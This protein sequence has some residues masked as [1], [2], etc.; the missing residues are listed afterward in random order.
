MTRRSILFSVV[1]IA[2]FA[3]VTPAHSADPQGAASVQVIKHFLKDIREAAG[4]RDPDKVRAVA[5]RYMAEDYIQHSSD[6]PPGREGF[7]KGMSDMLKSGPPPGSPPPG[8]P[9][10][11]P[12]PG[13]MPMPKDLDFFG[14]GEYVVWVSESME[15]GKLLFNMVRVVNG[16]MK[17][18][19]DSK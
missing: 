2:M 11:S 19:W 14:D 3:I 7:I 16:K 15:P 10:G 18:H 1:A 9:A 5:E 17:E 6:F 13:A 12:P 4:T 8:A